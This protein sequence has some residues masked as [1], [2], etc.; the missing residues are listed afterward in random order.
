MARY[1]DID[2]FVGWIE[3]LKKE[4]ENPYPEYQ[5]LMLYEI[6]DALENLPEVVRC[7]E[8]KNRCTNLCPMETVELYPWFQT[9]DEAFCYYGVRKEL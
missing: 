2:S 6:L 8:C 9:Y 3:A 7:K 4:C 5:T 1:V